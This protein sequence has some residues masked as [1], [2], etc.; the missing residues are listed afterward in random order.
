MTDTRGAGVPEP[1]VGRRLD[2]RDCEAAVRTDSDGAVVTFTGTVRDHHG[3]RTVTS[4]RYEAHPRAAEF[5]EQACQRHRTREVRVAAQHR[6]GELTI[7]EVA[8]VVAVSSAHRREAFAVCA[9]VIDDVK[10][11]VPIWKYETYADGD[12]GWQEPGC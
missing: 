1:I 12:A 7:G 9:A 11:S 6:V 2:P 5:L 4:L 3:G 10:S 8:V